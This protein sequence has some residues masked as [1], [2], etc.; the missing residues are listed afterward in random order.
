MTFS[1]L[2]EGDRKILEKHY[3]GNDPPCQMDQEDDR[4]VLK[5]QTYNPLT[6]INLLSKE[7]GY[8]IM[9][10]PGQ[11]SIPLKAGST[12]DKYEFDDDAKC[13]S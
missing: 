11:R 5:G 8:K 2:D 1:G 9:Y 12:D 6:V 7:R 3:R 4:F 13:C 10:N